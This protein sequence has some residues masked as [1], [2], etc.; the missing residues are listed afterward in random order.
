MYHRD[1]T[2]NHADST[3]PKGTETK[4]EDPLV[5]VSILIGDA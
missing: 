3:L 1:T 5:D 2:K 4:Y